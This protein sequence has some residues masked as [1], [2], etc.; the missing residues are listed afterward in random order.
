VYL[1]VVYG[2]GER[3]KLEIV[4]RVVAL[5][6]VWIFSFLDGVFMK[7]D[8]LLQKHVRCF[9]IIIIIKD[10]S[11]MVQTKILEFEKKSLTGRLLQFF[12]FHGIVC[13]IIGTN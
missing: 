10:N 8:R 5:I 9:Q 13:C 11:C 4:V 7:L 1:V 3:L 2:Q 6:S 12:Y